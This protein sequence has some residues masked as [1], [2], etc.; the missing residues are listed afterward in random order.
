MLFPV[1]GQH[2]DV[3]KMEPEING[4]RKARHDG[5]PRIAVHA[6]KYKRALCDSRDQG[7]NRLREV[8]A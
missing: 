3:V 1:N 8:S 5:A 2:D 4:I 7:V 6:R